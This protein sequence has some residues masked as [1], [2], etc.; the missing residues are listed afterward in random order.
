MQGLERLDL[1]PG[2]PVHV[3]GSRLVVGEHE[4]LLERMRERRTAPLSPGPPARA[5]AIGTAAAAALAALP[6]PPALLRRG[7][8]ALAAGRVREAVH[9]LAGLGEG[10]TP[11]GDDVLAGYAAA[12]AALGPSGPPQSASP[13]GARTVSRLAARRSSALGLAYLR[14]AERGEMPDAGARLLIA[15]CSGSVPA[16]RSALPPLR[17]WGASSGTALAWGM[18]AGVEDSTARGALTCRA[19]QG[20]EP[21]N[22]EPIGKR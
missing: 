21:S 15:I 4:I 7:I 22:A 3:I 1:P 2:S 14:C 18:A 20:E 5:S 17:A 13:D 11:A 8:A 10:L 12:R 9:S 16:V 6:D 19:R